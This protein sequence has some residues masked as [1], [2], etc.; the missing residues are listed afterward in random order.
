MSLAF[1]SKKCILLWIFVVFYFDG[2]I[3]KSLSFPVGPPPQNKN[4]HGKICK[5]IR[6]R[7]K[8][9]IS[10]NWAAADSAAAGVAFAAEQAH[11]PVGAIESRY[12]EPH[13]ACCT[14]PLRAH[15]EFG[16]FRAECRWDCV[17]LT[18]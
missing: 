2:F 13:P 6:V 3:Q 4:Y 7:C 10:K 15:V 17:C 14:T 12:E 11:P 18:M 8:L 1:I 9:F 16:I 5:N